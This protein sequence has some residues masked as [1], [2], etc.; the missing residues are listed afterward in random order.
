MSVWG[1]IRDLVFIP[2]PAMAFAVTIVAIMTVAVTLNYHQ[3][4]TVR[5]TILESRAEDIDYALDEFAS[6]SE[7]NGLSEQMEIERYF[8]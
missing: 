4:Q 6:M 7:E 2:K 8:L 3:Q 1:R 5:A